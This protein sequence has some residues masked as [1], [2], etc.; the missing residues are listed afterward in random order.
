MSTILL[1]DDDLGTLETCGTILRLAG[2]DVVT[3][4]SGR[5]GLNLLHDRA[6][7]AV[8]VDLGLP[9]ISGL[10]VMRQ[11]PRSVPFAVIT[12]FATSH[13]A[14][15]ALRLGAAEFLE[16]PVFEEQLLQAVRKVLS[17]RRNVNDELPDQ[18][19]AH[20]A[21]RWARALVPIVDSP[22]DPRTV[23]GWAQLIVVSPGAL[24]NWCRTA[25][26]SPRRSLVFARLLRVV[27]LSQRS[28]QKPE[29]LLDVVDLRTLS[30]LLKLCG[31]R[32]EDELP[33]DVDKFLA[34][35]ALVRDSDLLRQI[36][37]SLERRQSRGAPE[38]TALFPSESS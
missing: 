30:G 37:L 11:S 23:T 24:R 29:N 26:M 14:I 15:E 12:G 28:Q 36:K 32:V 16:K 3:A 2:Y 5:L 7:D 38:S 25:G 33:C 22:R 31:L 27:F 6:V 17:T 34:R 21:A 20:A 1:I 10:D 8:L 35:Q 4:A 19:E 18:H 9:D 13:A